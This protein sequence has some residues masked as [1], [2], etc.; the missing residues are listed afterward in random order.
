M[1]RWVLVT[2]V[3]LLAAGVLAA[4]GGGDDGADDATSPKTGG[5]AA[6]A[7]GEDTV[8]TL[9]EQNGSGESG[10]ATLTA[11]D[12][13]KTRVVVEIADPPW[14]SQPAHIH[15]GSCAELDPAPLYGL[16]NVMDGRS[17]TVVDAPLSELTAGGLAL[18]VHQSD[19]MLDH[20][21]ACGNLP[22]GEGAA[23]TDDRSGGY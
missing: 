18:N 16:L 23:V 7:S 2:L 20:Y 15:R 12:D 22:G 1:W 19:E 14:P 13:G 5:Q 10:T 4:C 11:T 6:A 21:V 8:V 3:G 9:A 17:E